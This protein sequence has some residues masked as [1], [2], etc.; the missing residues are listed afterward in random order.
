MAVNG[1]VIDPSIFGVLR[2]LVTFSVGFFR[3]IIKKCPVGVEIVR[4]S[5]FRE[6]DDWRITVNLQFYGIMSPL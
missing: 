1:F 2:I 4:C 5:I 3:H 6:I